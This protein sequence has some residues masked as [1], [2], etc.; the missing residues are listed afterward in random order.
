MAFS[1]FLCVYVL[2]H[3]HISYLYLYLKQVAA[4]I[5]C[6]SAIS[7]MCYTTPAQPKSLPTKLFNATFVQPDFFKLSENDF[8]GLHLHNLESLRRYHFTL[9]SHNLT[10]TTFVQL[11]FRVLHLHNLKSLSLW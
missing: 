8:R 9:H 7:N 4:R 6:S 1:F 5:C 10:F 2:L 3:I 11:H